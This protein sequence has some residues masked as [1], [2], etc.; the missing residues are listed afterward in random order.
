VALPLL[1][2]SLPRMWLQGRIKK[3]R[4]LVLKG[5]PDGIDLITTS[6]EAGLGIDAAIARVAEKVKGPLAEEFR[7][8]LREMSLGHT[9]RESLRGFAERVELEDVSAL[10]NAINQAEHTGVSLGQVIRIQA[11]QLRI[12]RRQRA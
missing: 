10:V 11:D 12:K 1:G 7:R 9:R 8:C 5:L 6:V 3:R 4:K 2:F